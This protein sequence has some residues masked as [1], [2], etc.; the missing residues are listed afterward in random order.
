MGMAVAVLALGA[1]GEDDPPETPGAC[2]APTAEYLAALEA[3]PREVQ[4]EGSTP[5]GACIVAEQ[6]PGT[7]ATVG[8]SLV[9][10]A[11][12]LNAEARRDPA[13]DAAVKLGYL[14]GAIDESAEATGGIHEDLRLRLASAARFTPGEG[15]L[16]ASFER[17]FAEGY[18]AGRADG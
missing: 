7:L 9:D 2:L 4:L 16:P 11:S 8:G 15:A 6:E 1:C 17:G 12:R 10:A 3:A 13:G 5:I 18:A 14:T